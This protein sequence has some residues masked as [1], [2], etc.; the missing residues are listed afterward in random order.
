[1]DGLYSVLPFEVKDKNGKPVVIYGFYYICDGGY[2]KFKYLAC[3][4]QSDRKLELTCVVV[5]ESEL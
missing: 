3:S 4:F 5:K 2:P 1:V